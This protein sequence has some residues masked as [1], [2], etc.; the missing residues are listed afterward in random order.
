MS[1]ETPADS[2]CRDGQGFVSHDYLGDKC[3]KCGKKLRQGRGLGGG[4]QM[5]IGDV[6]SFAAGLDR[7][8]EFGVLKRIDTHKGELIAVIAQ[9][10][11]AVVMRSLKRVKTIE[12]AH[13]HMAAIAKR[14]RYK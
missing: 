5:K 9:S 3:I 4:R 10:P 1:E 13:K 8:P 6:V 14:K 7:H 2:P 12:A 11:N